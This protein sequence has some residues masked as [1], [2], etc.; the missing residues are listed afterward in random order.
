VGLE[1]LSIFKKKARE[2]GSRI[3]FEDEA[4]FRQDPTLHRTWSRIGEQPQIAQLKKRSGI[5]VLGCVDIEDLEFKYCFEKTLESRSYIAFLE[6]TVSQFF[7]K[8]RPIFYI[9]DNASY[10]KDGDVWYWFKENRKW[11]EVFNLPPYC[12]E[13]NA[14]ERLWKYTRKQTTHNRYFD[15]LDL[16]QE[17]LCY[18]F[19]QMNKPEIILNN[20]RSFL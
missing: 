15:T 20:V 1:F 14:T 18:L 19:E 12:P 9:Q 17:N 13:L 8:D 16:L 11:I 2:Q 7:E 4:G 3:V 10:H 6:T 5:K